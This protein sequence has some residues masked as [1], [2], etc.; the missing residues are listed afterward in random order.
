MC[1]ST[2]AIALLG[3]I[4]LKVLIF[5]MANADTM[6]RVLAL[7]IIGLLLVVTSALYSKAARADK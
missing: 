7:L 1:L 3:I 4:A 2:I 5:D 6:W